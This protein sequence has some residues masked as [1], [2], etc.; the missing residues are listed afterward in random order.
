MPQGWDCYVRTADS[1]W[2]DGGRF[3][4]AQLLD[5]G[6]HVLLGQDACALQ[7]LGQGRGLPQGGEGQLVE[8]AEVVGGKLLSH[9]GN[10]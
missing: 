2:R 9:D 8:G 10:S 1:S 5:H 4:L 6:Q 3:A 7:Q